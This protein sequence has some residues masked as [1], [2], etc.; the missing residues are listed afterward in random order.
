MSEKHV[1]YVGAHDSV[2]PQVKIQILNEKLKDHLPAYATPDSAALDV[3]AAIEEPVTV[4]PGGI[5]FIPTGFAIQPPHAG[6]A[7]LLLPRSGLGTNGLVLAN[8]VGLIDADYTG[9]IM[10]AAWNRTDED[11]FVIEPWSRLCQMVFVPVIQID[12]KVVDE[13]EPTQRQ[14]GFGHTGV[15]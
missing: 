3:R 4:F 7:A 9:E 14:G 12:W 10:V 5:A 11:R 6:M 2:R 8:S 15:A 1:Q 13:L